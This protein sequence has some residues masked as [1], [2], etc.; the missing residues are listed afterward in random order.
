VEHCRGG[1][2]NHW[3]K[4]WDIFY[5]K[6]HVATSVFP[7]NKSDWL[8]GLVEWV[9]S[10]QKRWALSSFVISICDLSWVVGMLA[11]CITNFVVCFRDH[12]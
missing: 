10:E 12:I 9:Q 1:E 6:L 4:V 3:A 7:Y 2:C 5:A 8:F 11:V